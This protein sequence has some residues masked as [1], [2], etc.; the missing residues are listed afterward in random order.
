MAHL[1][2]L[3]SMLLCDAVI[4]D[5]LTKKKTLVGLFDSIH[6][7]NFPTI[8]PSIAVYVR[9]TDAAGEYTF[10][11]EL[12]DLKENKVIGRAQELRAT[13]PDRLRFTDL[14]FRLQGAQFPHAGKY[15]FRIL[16]N[17]RVFGQAAVS[18]SQLQGESI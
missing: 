10:T 17:G 11:L 6:A 3:N 7:F 2:K 16:A 4:V 18:L 15:E 12:V 1:P 8:H 14:I 9:C 5:E 13:L